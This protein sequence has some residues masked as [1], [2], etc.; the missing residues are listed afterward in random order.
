MEGFH[1]L[2]P[3]TAT[4]TFT[5]VI[6]AKINLFNMKSIHGFIVHIPKRFKDTIKVAGMDFFLD[7]KFDEFGNRICEGEIVS[8]PIGYTGDASVGDILHFH[9]HVVLN[10]KLSLGEDLF[11]V[12]HNAFGGGHAYAYSRNG[13]VSMIDDWV[14]LKAIDASGFREVNGIIINQEKDDHGDEGEVAFD[15]HELQ[16]LGIFAGDTVGFSKNSDYEIEVCG[17]K[18]WRMRTDDI[19]YLR[20]S[21]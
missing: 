11:L 17:S 19:N 8:L 9:H 20:R 15:S 10:D 18:Y 4:L 5:S 3:H 21:V 12:M 13:S 1:M 6:D 16:Q 7:P 2:E 14:F